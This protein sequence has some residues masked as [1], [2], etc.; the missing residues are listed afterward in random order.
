[1]GV[2]AGVQKLEMPRVSLVLIHGAYYNKASK[3]ARKHATGLH[4]QWKNY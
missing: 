3:H 4:G 2:S 1:M